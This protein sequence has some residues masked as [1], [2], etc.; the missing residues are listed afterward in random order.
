MVI[1]PILRVRQF[2]LLEDRRR[3][4][5]STNHGTQ[6]IHHRYYEEITAENRSK[7]LLDILPAGIYS[8]GYLT[9]VTDSRVSLGTWVAELRDGS[10]QISVR[11]AAAATLDSTTLDSGSI[12]S[13]TPYLVMRWGFNTVIANYVEI[14]A[15]A[16]LSARQENDVVIGRCVFDGATLSSFDYSD[17]TFPMIQDQNLRVEATSDTEMY[18][19]VRGGVVN[20]GSAKVRIGD[21][22]V[23]PFVA[24]SSPNS[25]IDLVYVTSTGALA[26]LQGIAAVSPSVP[27]YGSKLVVAEILVV[28]G[29]TNITWDRIT[30]ARAFLAFPSSSR[31][32]VVESEGTDDIS[33]NTAAWANIPDMSVNITTT[34][35]LVHVNGS[36]WIR[37]DGDDYSDFRVLVDGAVKYTRRLGMGDHQRYLEWNISRY[38]DLSAGAHTITL[39]WKKVTTA[40]YQD[41][42][43]YSRYLQA[44]EL[45]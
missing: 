28:N 38:F 36:V 31:T 27:A 26:I 29:D 33:Y 4:M 45:Q 13:A 6:D 23:G 37:T 17:R 34:G 10:S 25:R 39:Q 41:G 1:Q 3:G 15:L 40:I 2:Q 16:S 32:Q 8:G 18:V 12:S 21:Q 24:P 20:I 42:S 14:H 19:R 5:G 30:D 43:S 7:R 9:R 44:V 11:T 35:G 22:K